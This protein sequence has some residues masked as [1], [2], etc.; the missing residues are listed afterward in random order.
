VTSLNIT[1]GYFCGAV[2]CTALNVVLLAGDGQGGDVVILRKVL[3]F[4]TL[5]FFFIFREY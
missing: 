3:A 1:S 5:D 4:D 2:V